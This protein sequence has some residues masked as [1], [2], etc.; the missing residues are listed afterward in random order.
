MA[1]D[2]TTSKN[3][4]VNDGDYK[5]IK[6]TTLVGRHWEKNTTSNHHVQ[7]LLSGGTWNIELPSQGNPHPFG[8]SSRLEV[9]SFLEGLSELQ[10]RW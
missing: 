7:S 3:Y 1:W 9:L 5:E 6:K 4:P 10:S 8:F 2:E